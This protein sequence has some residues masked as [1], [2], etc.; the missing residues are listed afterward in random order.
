M[1]V[2]CRSPRY[3]AA[4][5]TPASRSAPTTSAATTD[6]SRLGPDEA[7]SITSNACVVEGEAGEVRGQLRAPG[8]PPPVGHQTSPHSLREAAVPRT[9]SFERTRFPSPILLHKVW[10]IGRDAPGLVVCLFVTQVIPCW[11]LVTTSIATHL[12]GRVEVA[13][14][15]ARRQALVRGLVRHLVGGVGVSEP[16]EP[17]H[18]RALNHQGGKPERR[19]AVRRPQRLRYLAP[20]VGS[21]SGNVGLRVVVRPLTFS[22]KPHH[23]AAGAQRVCPPRESSSNGQRSRTAAVGYPEHARG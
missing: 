12:S 16:L 13:C 15:G 17:R 18:V 20:E 2:Q 8:V 10:R 4:E 7:S 1:R 9:H 19:V 11:A 21:G 6:A 23:F 22:G 3:S 5:H 14:V